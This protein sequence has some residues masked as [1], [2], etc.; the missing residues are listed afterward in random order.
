[1][2]GGADWA[3]AQMKSDVVVSQKGRMD[4]SRKFLISAI[5]GAACVVA[6][7]AWAQTSGTIAKAVGGYNFD[8]AAKANQIRRT[9]IRRMAS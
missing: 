2:A 7:P 3:A 4:M 6:A 5:V 8:E 1:M 9:S